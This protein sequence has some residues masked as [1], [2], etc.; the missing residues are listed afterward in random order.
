M[1]PDTPLPQEEPGGENPPDGAV[2]DY[3]LAAD[4]TNV[5][6]EIV[7]KNGKVVRTYRSS[8]QPYKIPDLNIPLYWIR[9]F[10]ALPTTAGHHRF[11][12]DMHHEPL[13]VDVS[14]PM[15]AIYKN[16]A[17]E[18]TSPWVMP[19]EYTVRLIIDG[20]PFEQK[21]NVRMDPR[22]STSAAELQVQYNLSLQAWL[23]RKEVLDIISQIR[24]FEKAAGSMNGNSNNVKSAVKATQELLGNGSRGSGLLYLDQAW[25]GLFGLLQESDNPVT[26][27]AR[28]AVLDADV[29]HK[30]IMNRW[31]KVRTQ[32]KK[33]LDKVLG[34]SGK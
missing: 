15:S 17:P 5:V 34:S 3:E 16:T 29:M 32:H 6:L 20:Q 19:G 24:A 4:A 30:E 10:R 27:Q 9:P 31:S 28:K 25:A 13:N 23:G 18:P 11:Q 7:D 21:L 14:F 26:E 8:D 1:N 22:V 33:T 12:W 2:I